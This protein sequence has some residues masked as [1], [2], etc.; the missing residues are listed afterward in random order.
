[1]NKEDLNTNMA[2][3]SMAYSSHILTSKIRLNLK[4][5]TKPLHHSCLSLKARALHLGLSDVFL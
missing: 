3:L 1:M 5:P 4:A 2:G